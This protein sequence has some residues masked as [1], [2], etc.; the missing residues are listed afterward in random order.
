MEKAA[1]VRLRWNRSEPLEYIFDIAERGLADFRLHLAIGGKHDA[2]AMQRTSL[3][4]SVI[5]TLHGS[6]AS[7]L[8]QRNA[9]LDVALC[10]MDGFVFG[11]ICGMP[12]Y[13]HQHGPILSMPH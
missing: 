12:E 6:R 10:V 11:D 2:C 3:S 7:S 8:T 5:L 9:R 4:T 13:S 1:T